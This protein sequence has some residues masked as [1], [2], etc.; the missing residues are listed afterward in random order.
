MS[1]SQERA[2]DSIITPRVSKI[3]ETIG[4]VAQSER[5]SSVANEDDDPTNVLG[6]RGPATFQKSLMGVANEDDDPTDVLEPARQWE[7]VDQFSTPILTQLLGWHQKIIF[8][9]EY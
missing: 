5:T 9:T 3:R 4:V 8:F 1:D 6:A 2:N 7:S